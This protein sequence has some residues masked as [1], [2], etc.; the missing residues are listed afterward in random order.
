MY[1]S[2]YIM[3]DVFECAIRK[4][5]IHYSNLI[6]VGVVNISFMAIQFVNI[7]KHS[8]ITHCIQFF[9]MLY[10]HIYFQLLN[11]CRVLEFRQ[12]LRSTDSSSS[13]PLSLIH[14]MV[15][16]VRCVQ[17]HGFE[18]LLCPISQHVI[19]KSALYILCEHRDT[20][21]YLWFFLQRRFACIRITLDLQQV[22]TWFRTMGCLRQRRTIIHGKKKYKFQS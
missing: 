12:S 13:L 19:H 8:R 17:F 11:G 2:W 10:T 1:V 14:C 6:I 20:W 5:S 9:P 3:L 22:H 16:S 4:H 15:L 21:R 7:D 18:R